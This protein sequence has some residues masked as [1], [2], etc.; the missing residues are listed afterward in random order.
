LKRSNFRKRVFQL[1]IQI[2]VL[3]KNSV[4]QLVLVAQNNLKLGNSQGKTLEGYIITY[5]GVGVGGVPWRFVHKAQTGEVFLVALDLVILFWA[6]GVFT[7]E[8]K[9]TQGSTRLGHDLLELLILLLV[10]KAVLLLVV[11]FVAV[12]VLVGVLILVGWVELLSL[13]AVRDEVGGVTALKAASG[14][15]PPL[16]A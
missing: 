16:L 4:K 11:V 12:I 9:V 3:T 13:W 2:F 10:S 8:F 7:Q 1:K 14:W 5:I 15:S 6:R